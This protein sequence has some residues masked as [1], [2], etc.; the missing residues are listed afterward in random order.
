[1]RVGDELG[2]P[3]CAKE[4]GMLNHVCVP[5]ISLPAMEEE[6]MWHHRRTRAV[7]NPLQLPVAARW[8]LST[9]SASTFDI[10]SRL[11]DSAAIAMSE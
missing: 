8:I 3:A 5:S 1:M 10:S 2:L 7:I 6:T 9:C 11:P 4:M